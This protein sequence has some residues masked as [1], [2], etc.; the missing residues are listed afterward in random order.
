MNK[1]ELESIISLNDAEK[2][3]D[4]YSCQSRIWT[5]MR[6]LGVAPYKV[7]RDDSGKIISQSFKVVAK[8]VVIRKIKVMTEEAKAQSIRNLGLHGRTPKIQG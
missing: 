3:A 1:F 4:I 6:K 8:A 5:R 7:I 2:T